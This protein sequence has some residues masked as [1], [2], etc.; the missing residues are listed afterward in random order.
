MSRD[1]QDTV[2][3]LERNSDKFHDWIRERK[4]RKVEKYVYDEVIEIIQD[5]SSR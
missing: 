4:K 5:L 3:R 2:K 1:L